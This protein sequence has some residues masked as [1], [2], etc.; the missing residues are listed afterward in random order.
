MQYAPQVLAATIATGLNALIGLVI[1]AV[2]GVVLADRGVVHPR[3]RRHARARS[4]PRS[5]SCRSSPSRRCSTRCSARPPR[6]ARILIASLAAFV[7]V[8]LNTLRGLRQVRPVHR[9]LMRAY[10]ATSR[11]ADAVRHH[12]VRAAALLHGPAHRLVARRDL[13]ARRRVLRRPP[14]GLGSAITTAAASSAYAR[15]WAFVIGAI[16]LGLAFFALTSLIERIASR[17]R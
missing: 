16:L 2:L 6:S 12:P 15:A 7:P 9:D 5:R 1:G 11:Q 17:H 13:R 3:D 4:S 10:A 8:F 14:R